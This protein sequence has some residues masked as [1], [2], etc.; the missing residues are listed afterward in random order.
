VALV[1]RERGRLN[2]NK[3]RGESR[4]RERE[5]GT[6]RKRKTETLKVSKLAQGA[7]ERDCAFMY[8]SGVVWV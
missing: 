6:T 3:E 8:G 2:C 5:R 7:E 4:E 1:N